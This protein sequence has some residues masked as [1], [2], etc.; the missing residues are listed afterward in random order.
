M[1]NVA[2]VKYG[3]VH[4]TPFAI[5]AEWSAEPIVQLIQN[6]VATAS[7]FSTAR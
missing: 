4:A 5:P 7:T 6:A 2:T 3:D 1:G